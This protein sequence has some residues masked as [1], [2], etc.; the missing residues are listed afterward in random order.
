MENVLR[1]PVFLNGAATTGF[2][3][4]YSKELFK[5][6]GHSN[7]RANKLLL[8]LADMVR[9]ALWLS[10]VSSVVLFE[11]ADYQPLTC[12]GCMAGCG[13]LSYLSYGWRPGCGAYLFYRNVGI[14]G[15]AADYI[16]VFL[17]LSCRW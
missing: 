2:I 10:S 16:Y 3:E 15:F 6:E 12:N 7:A 14:V 11:R 5:F 17:V 1:H 13:F 4:T 8:Y 9:A